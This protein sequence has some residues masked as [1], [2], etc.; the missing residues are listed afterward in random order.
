MG[1]PRKPTLTLPRGI[2]AVRARGKSY[3]YFH[4]ARGTLRSSKAV[5]IPG[6]PVNLDGSPNS[7]WWEAYRGLSG[8]MPTVEPRGTFGAL[9]EAFKES[10]E[11]GELRPR[12]KAEWSRHLNTVDSAWR[13]LQVSGVQ[14]KHVLALRD[15]Q[16]HKPANAN[17][18]IRALSSLLS[19]SVPRGWRADNPCREIQKL[20]IGDGYA[21]WPWEAIEHFAVHARHDLWQAAALA[22][23]S[24]QRLADVLKVKWS[25]IGNGL[26]CVKQGKTGKTVWVPIHRRLAAILADVPRTS[27]FILTSSRKRPWSV[28]G[29]KASWQDELNRPIM[30]SLR[31]RR[32][33]FHG[34]R[35]SAVVT[36]LE[37]GATD[38]EVSAI[39]GQSREMVAHYSRQVNQR[40]LAAA[41]ILKWEAKDDAGG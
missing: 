20:K 37:A 33:V 15:V 5:R 21:P 13:N 16:K 7:A 22:L 36:L 11:W 30:R 8:Q 2:N 29:F 14:P 31:D 35:K 1:R 12:T 32:L 19:W 40:K 34:L 9:I 39:T 38:A 18:L 41:A 6:E 25:D 3:Y 27:V 17:N 10:P 28:H 24:G 26:I 23:F 4:P